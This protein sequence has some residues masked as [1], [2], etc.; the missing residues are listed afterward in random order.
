MGSISGYGKFSNAYRA[1]Q[2][3][4]EDFPYTILQ[5]STTTAQFSGENHAIS[6][7]STQAVTLSVASAN[8]VNWSA[9]ADAPWIQLSPVSGTVSSASPATLK[10]TV[11]PA[12]FLT[13]DTFT[14]TVTLLSGAAPP[15]FINVQVKMT[16]DT[17]NVVATANPD[18]VPESGSEWQL[19][20]QLQETGGAATQLTGMKIDG[21]DYTANLAGWFGSTTLAANGTLTAT[22]HTSG[23]LVPVTKYF[24][25]WG[26]D[27]LSG[28]TWYRLLA[29]T[30]TP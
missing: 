17:S 1:L 8:P 5:P 16:I 25:F 26:K 19:G 6:G 4:L 27:V 29:V 10:I 20:L 15:Q 9:R 11:N 28:N 14:G 7:N 23:L 18:P 30:F 2:P 21:V 3:Y 22:I 12:Y 24:E 13:S